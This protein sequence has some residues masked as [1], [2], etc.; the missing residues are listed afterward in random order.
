MLSERLI[1]GGAILL[2][3]FLL[4]YLIPDQVVSMQGA[5]DPSL[6]PR[7]AAWLFVGL[8][9]VQLL[10]KT[11]TTMGVDRAQF[12]RVCFL[13]LVALF[14]IILMPIVGYLA[15]SVGL[16]I[17]V[18]SV[19]FEKRWLWLVTSVVVVPVCVWLAFEILLRRPLPTF[20][21]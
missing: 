8:G 16:M 14:C 5:V 6:F 12:L 19:M 21:F 18:C 9:I 2:G 17:V 20:S 11:Q 7:V 1:G 10:T 13:C 4:F 3:A 15:A